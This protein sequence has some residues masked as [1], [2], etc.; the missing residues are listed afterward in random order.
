MIMFLQILKKG[1]LRLLYFRNIINE[2][3]AFSYIIFE[4]LKFLFSIILLSINCP[5]S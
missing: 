3:Y 1:F 4:K 2:K 5:F